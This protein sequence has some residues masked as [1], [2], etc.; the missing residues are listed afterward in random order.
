[1][2]RFCVTIISNEILFNKTITIKPIF[3]EVKLIRAYSECLGTRRRRRTRLPAKSDGELEVSFD[4]SMS[5]W[6]N[7][8]RFIPC[9]LARNIYSQ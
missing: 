3:Y 9:H 6:G 1:M 7:P 4:P 5:E 8:A 2:L